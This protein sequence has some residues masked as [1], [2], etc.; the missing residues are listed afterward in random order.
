VHPFVPD[1]SKSARRSRLLN[2]CERERAS[3]NMDHGRADTYM[4]REFIYPHRSVRS[5]PISQGRL[6]V[7]LGMALLINFATA[8]FGSFLLEVHGQ[9][10]KYILTCIRI[11]IKGTRVVEIFPFVG[12]VIAPYI[13]FPYPQAYPIRTSLLFIISV[14]VLIFIHRSIPLSRN[15]VVFLIVLLCAARVAIFVNPS[16]YFGSAAFEQMWLRG[17]VLVWIML[18]W[19]SAFLFVLTLP[20]VAGAVAWALMLQI[21]A[22]VWSALRL[23]FCLAVLNYT[24]VLFLPLIWFCLGLLFDLVY[25]LVFYSLALHKSMK[26]VIGERE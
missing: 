10:S 6:C 23:A 19:V 3:G 4:R 17:E 22:M 7:G 2:V 16:F 14:L 15:F 13:P 21:Y 12:S 9:L 5:F 1:F 26:K 18:P 25:V 24:G 20:S 8:Y 11:P